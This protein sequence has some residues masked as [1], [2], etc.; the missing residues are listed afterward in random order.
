MKDNTKTVAIAAITSI[1]VVSFEEVLDEGL[2]IAFNACGIDNKKK[3]L[4]GKVA[5]FI[6][7]I[8]IA[9]IVLNKITKD[10][11]CDDDK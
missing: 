3:A 2:G 4:M 7:I 5:V 1:L 8:L 10:D 6:I 9:V 11:E